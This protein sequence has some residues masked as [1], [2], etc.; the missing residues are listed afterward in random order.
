MIPSD[1]L[2][3]CPHR[4]REDAEFRGAG[5]ATPDAQLLTP[6]LRAVHEEESA[7]VQVP[8]G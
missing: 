2:G 7:N 6:E 4:C 8:Y 3:R 5:G 1:H